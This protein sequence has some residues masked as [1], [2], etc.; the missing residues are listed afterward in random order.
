MIKTAISLF[1]SGIILGA[2]PCLASCG[3]ILI[4]FIAATKKSPL[5]ALKSWFIFSASRVFIYAGLGALSGIIGSGIYQLFYWETPGYIIWL[6]G[7]IFICL[8]G[9]LVLLNKNTG[10]RICQRLHGMFIA[11]DTKSLVGLGF[12]M[13]I[14]PCAPLI[15]ILSYI[16]MVSIHFYQG[17][18]LALAFGLGTMISPLLFLGLATGFIPKFRI[19]QNEKAYL[20]F[21]RLAGTIL[22]FLGA[23]IIVK[24]I[25]GYIKN[26]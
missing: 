26:L 12:I 8:L 2:G 24:T 20:F 5:G 18:L 16:S 14:F 7:G 23:H 11:K 21:Q 6:I 13:G 1:A 9:I 25:I 3:P 15:G 10:S 4:S 22:F 17:I 19:L